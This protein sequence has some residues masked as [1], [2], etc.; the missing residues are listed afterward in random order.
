V[1]NFLK[2]NRRISSME[3]TL[4][5][6]S[7]GFQ[8]LELEWINAY[9]KLKKI[10]GRINKEASKIESAEE[11]SLGDA[12]VDAQPGNDPGRLLTPRQRQIQQQILKRRANVQ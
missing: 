11:H 9:A 10:V 12:P 5:K 2:L 7:S 4:E 1:F 8:S 3:E 6:L